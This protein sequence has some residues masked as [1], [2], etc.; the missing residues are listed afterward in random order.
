MRMASVP[1]M[2]NDQASSEITPR[3]SIATSPEGMLQLSLTAP[4]MESTDSPSTMTTSNPNRSERC[5]VFMRGSTRAAQLLV[6][7][8]SSVT[9]TMMLTPQSTNIHGLSSQIET[10]QS[11][12]VAPL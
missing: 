10:N 3:P 11:T 4:T 12:A 5:S 8:T 6:L 7:V 9:S 2:K 1:Y